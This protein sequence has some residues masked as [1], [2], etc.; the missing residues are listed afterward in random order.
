MILVSFLRIS[1]VSPCQIQVSGH[2]KEVDDSLMRS[3]ESMECFY[4]H[5]LQVVTPCSMGVDGFC[6]FL[7][8]F[9]M[10]YEY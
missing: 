10:A 8:G 7:M 5:F 9:V 3:K 2:A 4:C 6:L 1:A